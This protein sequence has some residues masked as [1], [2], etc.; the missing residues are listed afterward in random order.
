M[1]ERVGERRRVGFFGIAP[2]LGPLTKTKEWG[3]DPGI[4]DC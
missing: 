2:L 3:E 4:A 1:E